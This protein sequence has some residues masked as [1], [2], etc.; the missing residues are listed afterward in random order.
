[1]SIN[2]DSIVEQSE[3]LMKVSHNIDDCKINEIILDLGF[4]VPHDNIIVQLPAGQVFQ[5]VELFS[6]DNVPWFA[7][8]RVG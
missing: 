1:M 6:L 3:G 4:C 2:K 5:K 8:R 7:W